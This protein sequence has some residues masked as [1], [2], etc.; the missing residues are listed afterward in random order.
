[1]F[2]R[3]LFFICWILILGSFLCSCLSFSQKRRPLVEEVS[4]G[5]YEKAF[6]TY[7]KLAKR[8]PT[9][10]DLM[11]QGLILNLLKKHEESNEIFEEAERKIEELVTKSLSREFGTY[12]VNDLTQAYSGEEFERIYVHIM[13][14][15][16]YLALGKLE[17]ALVEVRKIDHE[18][19]VYSDYYQGKNTFKDYAF[20]HYLSGLIH[21][22]GGEFN[23][24]FI[25]Y[26][27]AYYSYEEYSGYFGI[28]IPESLKTDLLY[29]SLDLGFYEEYEKF[30]QKF[31]MKMSKEDVKKR[32]QSKEI[33]LFVALGKVAHK[34]ERYWGI[35]TAG[36]TVL[37]IAYPEF[38]PTPYVVHNVKRDQQRHYLESFLVDDVSA[39]AIRT[40]QDRISFIKAKAIARALAKASASTAAGI[41]VAKE[42][43][44]PGW[45]YLTAFF[46]NLLLSYT[47]RADTRSWLTLP[48]QI[49]L[50]RI[51][52]DPS[53]NEK[54]FWLSFLDESGETIYGERLLLP[55]SQSK[56][57]FF[58]I[59]SKEP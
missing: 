26:R 14:A 6:A 41:A 55:L 39:V 18:L 27:K 17:S 28:E 11:D 34:V 15:F 42:T 50:F 10:I 5:E 58:F 23:D 31:S 30:S 36:G 43:N 48:E 59:R 19:Q 49:R 51:T 13:M 33:I 16:N 12:L 40:L 2:R 7:K 47:E 9:L 45:G 53:D 38:V 20:A 4:R 56:K 57:S 21:E 54:S 35:D 44:S 37:K 22:A 29:T 46:T 52:V 8:K 1:M 24:A 32:R 25:S 3:L